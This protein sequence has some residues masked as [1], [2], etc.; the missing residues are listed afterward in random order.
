MEKQFLEN[1][2]ELFNTQQTIDMA[3]EIGTIE[4]WDSLSIVSFAAMV[5]IKYDQEIMVEEVERAKT[6]HDLYLLIECKA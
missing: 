1:F 6:V 5:N 3:T 2:T 4:E